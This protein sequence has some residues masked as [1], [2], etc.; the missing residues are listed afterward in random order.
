MPGPKAAA[1]A[2]ISPS[3]PETAAGEAVTSGP[4]KNE[5]AA[6]IP[7]DSGCVDEF[8]PTQE[9]FVDASDGK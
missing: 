8:E 2:Q 5:K 4:G 9:E 3:E 1:G 7:A 6:E